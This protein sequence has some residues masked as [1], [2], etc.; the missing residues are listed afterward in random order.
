M[1]DGTGTRSDKDHL[2]TGG[3][4][5]GEA[6]GNHRGLRRNVEYRTFRNVHVPCQSGRSSIGC[7]YTAALHT[8]TGRHMDTHETQDPRFRETGTLLRLQDEVCLRRIDQ[9]REPRSV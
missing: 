1:F 3:T 5:R 9:Y 8:C 4:Y 7:T 2:P 6:G